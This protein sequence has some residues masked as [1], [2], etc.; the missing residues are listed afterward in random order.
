MNGRLLVVKG[1]L[2]HKD[3]VTHIIAGAL[4]DHSSALASLPVQSRDFH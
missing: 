3:G 1:T 4:E 2:E